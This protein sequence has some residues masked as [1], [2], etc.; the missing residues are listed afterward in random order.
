[1]IAGPVAYAK[2]P[3]GP[4]RVVRTDLAAAAVMS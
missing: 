4:Y 2:I 1:M 3:G